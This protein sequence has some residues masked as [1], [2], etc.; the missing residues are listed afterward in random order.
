[1]QPGQIM[2]CLLS[3]LGSSKDDLELMEFNCVLELQAN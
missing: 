1:M 2:V 3:S